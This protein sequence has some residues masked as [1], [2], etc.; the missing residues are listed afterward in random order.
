MKEMTIHPESWRKSR[1]ASVPL[2]LGMTVVVLLLVFSGCSGIERHEY[3]FWG[4]IVPEHPE[5]I[6]DHWSDYGP[7][8]PD[9]RSL[10]MRRGKAGV[11]RFYKKKDLERSIPVDGELVVYVYDGAYGGIELTEPEYKLVIPS[12][13]LN[14]QRKFDKENGYSYH[15]WLDLGEVDLP[16][17]SISII[18]VFTENKTR[19]QLASGITYT[20][21]GGE[22]TKTDS[23]LVSQPDHMAAELK[24]ARYL[25]ADG[26]VG[27][28]VEGWEKFSD[29]VPAESPLAEIPDYPSLTNRDRSIDSTLEAEETKDQDPPLRTAM[30]FDLSD[31]M[32]HQMEN[33][34]GD[35]Y[36]NAPATLDS[37]SFRR[38]LINQN[39]TNGVNGTIPS[40]SSTGSPDSTM[41]NGLPDNR[42]KL[43][44]EEMH[45][46]GSPSYGTASSFTR[47]TVG[48]NGD[49][50]NQT[51][52]ESASSATPS[53]ISGAP[54]T[55]GGGIVTYSAG[56]SLS[57]GQ[58]L[59]GY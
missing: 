41:E 46:V 36:Q 58:G 40:S 19:D 7:F 10:K 1:P 8:L 24:K 33:R 59:L 26:T 11:I 20:Q 13:K 45:S 28:S 43:S 3:L 23:Q 56:D 57:S 53:L 48:A 2:F 47:G 21:I 5:E 29:A 32:I 30:T 15:V 35:A 52:S 55:N 4:E 34:Q 18:A 39:G 12:Q 27:D 50:R 16:P 49:A 31:S 51:G 22:P 14:Q 25:P 54:S 17:K 6:E 9:D 42:K 37:N 44:F 38:N